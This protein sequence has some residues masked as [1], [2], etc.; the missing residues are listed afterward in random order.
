MRRLAIRP[1]GIGDSIL[2]FPAIHHLALDAELEV[3]ARAEVLPLLP[4]QSCTIESSGIGLLGVTKP[5]PHL[6]D[7][8]SRFDEIVSWYG[9]AR[10]EFRQTLDNI[11]PRVIYLAALPAGNSQHASDFFAS[12]V[13][14]PTP[15]I[16]QIELRPTQ[17][18]Q[19]GLVVIH[20]F[21]GSAQKDWSL[22]RYESLAQSLRL[23]GMEVCFCAAS[24]QNLPGARVISDLAELGSFI[25]GA[26]LYIGNDS[27][28]THLAAAC[29]A[30]VLALFGAS[31]A[32]VWAPRGARVRVI[33]SGDLHTLSN[34]RVLAAVLA[35]P[36]F[37]QDQP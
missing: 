36:G 27:G 5:S 20:P 34:E 7:R 21:S 2:G 28:I 29:G 16:P 14:A 26:S 6:L 25:K 17:H 11:H 1:G 4:F 37:L 32:Q 33:D 15:S 31:D 23:A 22:D 10:E 35:Q 24:H 3:W 13:G 8:L 9:S 18:E 12:Q 30:N 19:P